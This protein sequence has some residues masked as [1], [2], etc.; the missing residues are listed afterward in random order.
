F[1]G[2]GPKASKSVSVDTSNEI[3]KAPDA[4][5]IED[6]VSDNDEDESEEMILNSENV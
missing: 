5:I 6:W 1:E 4:P 3:K 2:Y